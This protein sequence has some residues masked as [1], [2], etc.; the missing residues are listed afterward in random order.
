[1]GRRSTK[2][3]KTIYQVK[4]EELELSRDQSKRII[5]RAFC[6]TD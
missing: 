2:K 1:M 5:P 4:R 6:S 3:N